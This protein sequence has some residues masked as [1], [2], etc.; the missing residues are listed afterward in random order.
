MRCVREVHEQGATNS[1]RKRTARLD[2][3]DRHH[4]RQRRNPLRKVAFTAMRF[5]SSIS[6]SSPEAPGTTIFTSPLPTCDISAAS[7]PRDEASERRTTIPSP[8]CC[9]A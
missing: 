1:R 5:L 8:A 2:R 6:T 7:W 4:A 3:L 9:A